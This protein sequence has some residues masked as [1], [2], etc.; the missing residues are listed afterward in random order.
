MRGGKEVRTSNIP[1]RIVVAT[2]ER[3]F[4]VGTCVIRPSLNGD[5]ELRN[6]GA[7]SPLSHG[8]VSARDRHRLG[9]MKLARLPNCL[10]GLTHMY[11]P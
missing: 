4:N 1:V 9:G 8:A 5:T 3:A 6:E 7:I 2:L 10:L 11:P